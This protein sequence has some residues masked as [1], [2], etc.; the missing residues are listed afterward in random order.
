MG[1]P[2]ISICEN[3]DADQL[4]GNPEADQRLCFRYT[5]ST[6]FLNPKFQACN[7]YTKQFQTHLEVH[8]SDRPYVCPVCK[9][10]FKQQSQMK[11]HVVIHKDVLTDVEGKWCVNMNVKI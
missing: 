3:K 6:L 8:S 11:N 4:R 1:K 10:G 5:D 9:K 2:T 7:A